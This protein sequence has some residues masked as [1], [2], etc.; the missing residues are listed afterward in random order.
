MGSIC[1]FGL[2][3]GWMVVFYVLDSNDFELSKNCLV[4]VDEMFDLRWVVDG[5]GSIF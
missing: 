4:T 5:D 3:R 1:C 2:V